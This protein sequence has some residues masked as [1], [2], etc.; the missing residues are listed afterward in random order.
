MKAAPRTDMARLLIL[1]KRSEQVNTIITINSFRLDITMSL[2]IIIFS[3]LY[4]SFEPKATIIVI[5]M[6]IKSFV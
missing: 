6:P 3:I 5:L 2:I 1:D 4:I